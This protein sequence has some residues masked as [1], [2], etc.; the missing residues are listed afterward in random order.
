MSEMAVVTSRRSRLKQMGERNRG[1]RMALALAER[2]ERFLS[3]V[4]IGITLVGVLTGAIGGVAIADDVAVLMAGIPLLAD[5]A[6]PIGLGLSVTAI[7]FL[8]LILGELVPKRLALLDAE[9]IADLVQLFLIA[10][11]DREHLRIGVLL[12][13]GRELSA[14]AEAN[15]GRAKLGHG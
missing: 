4:Q 6:Q 3:T 11:A 1:A 8:T 7:T 2:P 14:K 12:I 10:L 13:D 5:Y 9:R 15:D